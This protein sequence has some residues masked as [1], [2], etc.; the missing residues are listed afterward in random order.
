MISWANKKVSWV[1]CFYFPIISIFYYSYFQFLRWHHC[2][3]NGSCY[4]HPK[5]KKS[6]KMVL[7]RTV[8]HVLLPRLG[9]TH[10]IFFPYMAGSRDSVVPP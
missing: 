8:P 1:P 7:L 4:A 10:T 6:P 9:V 3:T 2:N 5:H